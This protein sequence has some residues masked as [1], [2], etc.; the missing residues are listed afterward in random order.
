MKK[1]SIVFSTC[2]ILAVLF[3]GFLYYLRINAEESTS[4]TELEEEITIVPTYKTIKEGD[5]FRTRYKKSLGAVEYEYDIHDNLIGYLDMDVLPKLHSDITDDSIS[6]NDAV[7][8]VKDIFKSLV[9]N[10][11]DFEITQYSSSKE[12]YYDLSLARVLAP[13]VYDTMHAKVSFDGE[14]FSCVVKYCYLESISDT[15][16]QDAEEQVRLYVE[17]EV[18]E[19]VS[20]EATYEYRLS[21]DGKLLAY[22]TMVFTDKEE[23]YWCHSVIFLLDDESHTEG[24]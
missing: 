14:I 22:V 3:A 10:I 17:K 19:A 12:G 5:V 20:Y 8:L 21:D 16:R 1:R 23:N 4:A 15:Q 11:H 9:P 6:E 7:N 18:P 13:D 24:N 2:L